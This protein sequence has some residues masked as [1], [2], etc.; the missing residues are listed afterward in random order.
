MLINM[1][2]GSPRRVN[3]WHRASIMCGCSESIRNAPV[4]V[5]RPQADTEHLEHEKRRQKVF[6]QQGQAFQTPALARCLPK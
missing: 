6:L 3:G 1:R 4:V 5:Q 2:S